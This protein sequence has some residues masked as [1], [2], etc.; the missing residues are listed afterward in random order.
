MAIFRYGPLAG[1]ISGTV[2]GSIFAQGKTAPNVR[3]R[4]KA[5]R[6]FTQARADHNAVL[7]TC[8]AAWRNLTDNQ[9]LTWRIR[10]YNLR[11]VSRI[12]LPFTPTARQVFFSTNVARARGDLSLQQTTPGGGRAYPPVGAWAILDV[13]AGY[14]IQ[15]LDLV[16]GSLGPF[17]VHAC[18]PCQS[19]PTSSPRAWS[20]IDTHAIKLPGEVITTKF[21]AK[22]GV[23]VA[24]EYVYFKI[25]DVSADFLTSK[26]F[27]FEAVAA[28]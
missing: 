14:A 16:S 18:R 5:A 6:P 22:L 13:S 3:T 11:Y 10:A 24:G 25:R 9:R 20:Y 26:P 28:P 15:Y 7:A 1:P 19:H 17:Q 21:Q 23:L 12:G 4:P 2:G 8:A 27:T